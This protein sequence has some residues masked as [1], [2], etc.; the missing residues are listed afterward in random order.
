MDR[1]L[2]GTITLAI[3]RHRHTIRHLPLPHLSG[4][5]DR[6]QSLLDCRAVTH[7]PLSSLNSSTANLNV[8][9][10]LQVTSATTAKVKAT[11]QDL[12]RY[13]IKAQLLRQSL[14]TLEPL[15][16]HKR[17]L[18]MLTVCRP[19]FTRGEKK[20]KITGN[21]KRIWI[22]QLMAL[23]HNAY[24]IRDVTIALSS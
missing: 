14:E 2:A 4:I 1:N 5:L 16:R 9:Y 17:P 11:T 24:W 13:V 3:R 19:M 18:H 6:L 12:V 10:P 7:P 8:D 15:L 23:R 20:Q 21:P 22:L